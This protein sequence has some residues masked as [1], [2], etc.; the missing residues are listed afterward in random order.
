MDVDLYLGGKMFVGQ[1]VMSLDPD[2]GVPVVFR[3][4]QDHRLFL[5]LFPFP[6]GVFFA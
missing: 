2:I 4:G 3:N 5:F 1:I 6:R